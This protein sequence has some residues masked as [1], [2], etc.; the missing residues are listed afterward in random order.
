[1]TTVKLANKIQTIL[2]DDMRTETGNKFSLMGIF[3]PSIV[4]K[5]IPGALPQLCLCIMIEEVK[6]NFRELNI[7]LKS[8][9]AEDTHLKLSLPKENQVG[10]NIVLFAKI[11]PFRAKATG[12]AKLEVRVDKNKIPLTIHKFEIQQAT[13]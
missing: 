6:V 13:Q 7:T 10:L 2:C 1:M 3:G 8:P 4:F 12:P 5:K 9:E 11:I